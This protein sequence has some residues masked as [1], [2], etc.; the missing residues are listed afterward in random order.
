MTGLK[1][2]DIRRLKR[3]LK[4]LQ[5]LEGTGLVIECANGVQVSTKTRGNYGWIA[6]ICHYGYLRRNGN[7]YVIST[8]DR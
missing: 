3:A 5:K 8:E 6:P 1:A 7:G 2:S 4:L